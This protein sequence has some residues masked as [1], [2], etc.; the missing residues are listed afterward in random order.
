MQV[1]CLRGFDTLGLHQIAG[2]SERLGCQP[3]PHHS[4][5]IDEPWKNQVALAGIPRKSKVV[6]SSRE[7]RA[8][9]LRVGLHPTWRVAGAV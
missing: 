2:G 5:E 1:S 8:L 3:A 6:R 9:K 4:G 7:Q